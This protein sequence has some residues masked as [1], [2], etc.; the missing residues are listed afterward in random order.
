MPKMKCMRMRV[1]K[2]Q[3]SMVVNSDTHARTF[4]ICVGLRVLSMCAMCLR[5]VWSVMCLHCAAFTSLLSY[6]YHNC[7]ECFNSFYV[8]RISLLVP[9]FVQTNRKITTKYCL[10]HMHTFFTIYYYFGHIVG[11]EKFPSKEHRHR[12][13]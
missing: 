2:E 11:P 12:A 6:A 3:T 1:R 7:F 8:R 13:Q 9:P 5:L 10:L 4:S